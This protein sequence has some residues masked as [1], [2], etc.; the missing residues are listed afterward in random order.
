MVLE[1]CF[2]YGAQWWLKYP[3]LLVT[4][5]LRVVEGDTSH[6]IYTM[7]WQEYSF[8]AGRIIRIMH[9]FFRLSFHG[10]YVLRVAVSV[11]TVASASAVSVYCR[12]LSVT[13]Q[14]DLS[15]PPISNLGTVSLL[16]LGDTRNF[17]HDMY[18]GK[19]PRYSIYRD[20][21]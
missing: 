19:I 17:S 12:I 14:L 7:L 18:R 15:A 20:T 10:N 21:I 16:G 1:L 6:A 9:V 4:R 13:Q 11:R 5:I 2:S 3:I 8:H